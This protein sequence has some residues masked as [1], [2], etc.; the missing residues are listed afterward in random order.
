MTVAQHQ[1]VERRR[2]DPQQ[3]DVVDQCLRGEAEV[4]QDVARL[5]AA[6]IERASTGRTR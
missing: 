4:H 2:I 6:W 3:I 5:G 1:S